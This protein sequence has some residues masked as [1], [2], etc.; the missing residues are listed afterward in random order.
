[1][2][3]RVTIALGTVR[4]DTAPLVSLAARDGRVTWFL[5]AR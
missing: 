1:M 3:P 2:R 5:M 4:Y